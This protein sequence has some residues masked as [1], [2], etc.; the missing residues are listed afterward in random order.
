MAIRCPGCSFTKSRLTWTDKRWNRQV[1]A[2]VRRRKCLRCGLLFTTVEIH[3]RTFLDLVQC[4]AEQPL[5]V[6]NAVEKF[7]KALTKES[8]AVR[9]RLKTLKLQHSRHLKSSS[10]YKSL[11]PRTARDKETK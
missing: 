7:R 11:S 1:D 3:H 6:L 2:T 9:E 4:A 5:K 8:H 10:Y